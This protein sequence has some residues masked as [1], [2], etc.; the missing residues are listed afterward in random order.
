MASARK[1]PAAA[2]LLSIVPG[3]GHLYA[4]RTGAGVVWLGTVFVCYNASPAFGF[5]L[6]LVCAATAAQAA[7][8]ANR[9]EEADLVDRR[10]SAEEV[11]EIL[12]RT[13]A[14]RTPAPPAPAPAGPAV[15]PEPRVVRGAF[16]VPPAVLLGALS[17]AMVRQG[18]LVLGVD[19]DHLRLRASLD[20][21]GG[22]FASVAGQV[23]ATPAG[24]RVRL[25]LDR[26]EGTPRDP[27]ADDGALRRL[28]EGAEG[29]LAEVAPGM[30]PQ[31]PAVLGSGEA[32]TEDHFLEQLREAW[33]ARE[34]GWLP[35]EEWRQRKKGLLRGLVLRKG[36]RPTDFMAACRPLAEAG[37]L[38]P[39]DLRALEASLRG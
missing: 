30:A 6:H 12:D 20:L 23:E 24:S 37:V 27:A 16:P 17:E 34:Q 4:G 32:L 10:E 13:S 28:L 9:A 36:T 15:D 1:N 7:A 26:P 29:A 22:A 31:G 19:R 38:D 35:E 39:E 14:G 2:L 5:L 11:A 33:E 8:A 18:L 3:V 25:L 21:G